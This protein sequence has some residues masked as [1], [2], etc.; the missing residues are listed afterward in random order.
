MADELARVEARKLL[1]HYL[2]KVRCEDIK[3]YDV[4]GQEKLRSLIRDTS[5]WLG[6]NQGA[7]I[8]EYYSKQHDLTSS[9]GL[10]VGRHCVIRTCKE[11]LERVSMSESKFTVDEGK[12]LAN[13]AENLLEW[14]Q[15][16][17]QTDCET[18]LARYRRMQA[19]VNPIIAEEA[20]RNGGVRGALNTR[21]DGRLHFERHERPQSP[22]RL[23]FDSE[24]KTCLVEFDEA[25]DD[26][27]L[28]QIVDAL[29]V[30]NAKASRGVVNVLVLQI[31]GT[32]ASPM[33]VGDMVRSGVFMVGL[34]S[35]VPAI[36][37]CMSGTVVGPVW[38]LLLGTDYRIASADAEL[39]LPVTAAPRCLRKLVGESVA[40]HLCMEA[41]VLSPQ[42]ALSMGVLHEVH[43]T[44]DQAMKAAFEFACRISR[45]SR[46][47]VRETMMELACGPEEFLNDGEL[48]HGTNVEYLPIHANSP[49]KAEPYIGEVVMSFA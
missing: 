21:R 23:L 30:M 20:A 43:P 8:Q 47:S 36:I 1:E 19:V 37:G 5:R 39:H 29:T 24:R 11:I 38:A 42:D 31:R 2:E 27:D 3:L 15:R 28:K 45:F 18:L 12:N 14:V 17:A 34:R 10:I 16:H 6:Q 35:A 49:S 48:A 33:L 4:A 44:A 26:E 40:T 32:A 46:N 7:S 9:A 41:G 25:A 22:P 13:A